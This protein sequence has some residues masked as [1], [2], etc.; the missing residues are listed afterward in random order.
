MVQLGLQLLTTLIDAVG[1][2][3]ACGRELSAFV[4]DIF[5]A[6]PKNL[7]GSGFLLDFVKL[8]LPVRLEISFKSVMFLQQS[9]NGRHRISIIFHA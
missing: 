6:T 2:M 8:Y 5:A 9:L 7:Y 1:V 4:G 3:I